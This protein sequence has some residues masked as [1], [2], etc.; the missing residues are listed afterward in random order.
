MLVI[1][2]LTQAKVVFVNGT[3]TYIPENTA[4]QALKRGLPLK[5]KNFDSVNSVSASSKV[6]NTLPC[7]S[8]LLYAAEMK[9]S[10]VK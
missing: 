2:A 6:T 10:P 1:S 4:Q 3:V 5:R 8:W 7:K 9:T